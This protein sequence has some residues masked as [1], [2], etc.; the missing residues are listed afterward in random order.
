MLKVVALFKRKAGLTPEQFREYYETRHSVLSM[1][2]MPFFSDYRRNYIRH[3]LGPQ[4]SSA[5][6]PKSS[7]DFD[8]ITEITFV[9]RA[10]YDAMLQAL[11]DP[12]IRRQ[13]IDDE[14]QFMDRSATL[15]YMVD[16]CVSA[17]PV[18]TEA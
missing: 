1:T 16:E 14:S 11:S 15:S 17:I 13:V 4:R 10:D 2:L 9:S 3:D 12:D 18:R 8:V 7:L 6:A 5:E